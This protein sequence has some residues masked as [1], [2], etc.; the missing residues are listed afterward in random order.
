MD[1]SGD[2][3]SRGCQAINEETGDVCG[4]TSTLRILDEFRKL[5]EDRIRKIS[6]GTDGSSDHVRVD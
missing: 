1:H 4:E 2:P 6:E 5:Y 3:R